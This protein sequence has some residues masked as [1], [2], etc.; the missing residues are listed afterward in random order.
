MNLSHLR[1]RT[2]VGVSCALAGAAFG[3]ASV[4]AAPKHKK[5]QSRTAQTN[6]VR[7][8]RGGPDGPMRFGGPPVHATAVVLN[9]AGNAYITVTEDSGAYKSLNANTLVISEGV[10]N[11]PYQ[12]ATLTIPADAKVYRNDVA[13]K[14]SD[15]KPGDRV[16]VSQ[17]TQGTFVSADDAAHQR[18][19][20]GGP[21][22]HGGPDGPGG[23]DG[24]PPPPPGPAPA[25]PPASG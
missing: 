11:V 23:F 4:A 21:G 22:H 7:N 2:T 8:H 19:G 18:R 5:T 20:H 12:D 6:N 13:A 24:P 1:S 17:S 15:L 10:N 14:L 3:I 25:G 16:H 9:Q